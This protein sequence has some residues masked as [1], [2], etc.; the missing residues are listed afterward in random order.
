[1]LLLQSQY[2]VIWEQ[3]PKKLRSYRTQFFSHLRGTK[4]SSSLWSWFQ[5]ECFFCQHY[6]RVFVNSSICH[7]YAVSMMHKLMHVTVQGAPIRLRMR[8]TV[9]ERKQTRGAWWHS[10][11]VQNHGFKISDSCDFFRVRS[12][13]EDRDSD[14]M[15]HP[16]V[17]ESHLSCTGHHC[18]GRHPCAACSGRWYSGVGAGRYVRF[19]MRLQASLKEF[20]ALYLSLEIKFILS[21]KISMHN[22]GD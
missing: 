19:R 8:S 9:V 6:S 1:M 17:W 4:V 7:F 22:Y 11:C 3:N 10:R 15:Q 20:D 18:N 21:K 13:G 2:K 12:G 5:S 14:A 16:G